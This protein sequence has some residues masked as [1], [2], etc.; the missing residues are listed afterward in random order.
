[1]MRSGK[2]FR[3]IHTINGSVTQTLLM[4][5]SIL[6]LAVFT[7]MGSFTAS[8]Q[9]VPQTI[10]EVITPFETS[11]WVY[12]DKSSRLADDALF[13]SYASQLGLTSR[14][15]MQLEA[16]ETD[17]FGWTHREYQQVHNGVPVEFAVYN[18]HSRDGI[19]EKANG[20]IAPRLNVQTAP[21]IGEQEALAIALECIGAETYN[22]QVPQLEVMKRYATDDPNATFYPEGQLLIADRD[23][24]PKN[25]SQHTLAWK[26]EIHSAKPS[27]RDWVYVDA[28]NGI[29]LKELD[30]CMHE[31]GYP[32]TAETR[33]NGTVEIITD[34]T[35]LGF[36][37]RDYT[38]GRGI[39]TYDAADSF[40]VNY[41]VDFVDD[42]NYWAN[43]NDRA[44]DAATDCHWAA[45][46]LYDYL[47]EVHGFDSYD[48]KGSKMLSYVH[49]GQSWFNA[50]WNGFWSQ[51]G[52]AS[53]EPWV[54]VD[55][56]GHE[57]AHGFTWASAALLYT[58]ESGAMNESF[59]DILG[60][61]LQYHING[62]VTDWLATPSPVDTIRD[63]A[64]PNNHGHPDTYLGDNWVT[65]P[66]DNFGVHSNSG[67]Q[68]KWF[69]LLVNGGQGVNDNGEEYAVNPI[70]IDAAMQVVMRSMTTYLFPEA[71]YSDGRQSSLY[72][73]E[74]IFGVC[75]EEYRQIANAWHAVGV[76]QRV[77]EDDF[78]IM[79]IEE[80]P[81]CNVAEDG[82]LT[83]NLRHMGC[84]S[85][86]AVNISARVSKSNPPLSYTEVIDIPEG[87]G[88]GEV[89]SYTFNETFD[90]ARSGEHTLQIFLSSDADE[91]GGN[92]VSPQVSVFQLR[93]VEEHDFRFYTN[94]APRTFRDSM[95]FRSSQFSTLRI[96]NF[97]GR[98]ST[99]GILIEGDRMR[100]G[101]VVLEGED[102]FDYNQRQGTEICMCMDATNLDSLGL[103]FDLR[104]T[105][106]SKFEERVQ[107]PQPKT[108]AM[109]IMAN[110]EE[111]VRYFPETNNDDE[112]QTHNLD[113]EDYLGLEFTL[114]F[115]TR[116]IQSLAEDIDSIGDRVF[117]D[118]II[119]Q[120]VEIASGL[121]NVDP[122]LP[123]SI[124]PNPAS[125][126]YNV[127]FESLETGD[128]V[129]RVF[130]L[131]GAL[132]VQRDVSIAQ[133]VNRITADVYG[134]GKGIYVVEIASAGQRFVGRLAVL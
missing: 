131:N 8:S 71:T 82:Q 24:D 90:F 36:V 128:G 48:N 89:F 21:S 16:I 94:I 78:A 99:T 133:G 61:A 83:I 17:E 92:D 134:L 109:R 116:T 49:Y 77:D 126:E 20:V 113:L 114:C 18:V 5:R 33:Y 74:D 127:D 68:N 7:A 10:D 4:K 98:D 70:G 88:P 103:Q 12:I 57:F 73:A 23:F 107:I 28:N 9:N 55:V 81:L 32:G 124:F 65:T 84:D 100:Y 31:N 130:D 95:S 87:V 19:A 30:L 35:E 11:N 110:G 108:S 132:M 79:S 76:G 22:W 43:S 111:L 34:S 52:D 96:L 26:F 39:E 40:S 56:V 50:S 125:G 41:A 105:Y 29:I 63:Y 120:S 91:N 27:S 25:K 44:D 104:Q 121:V 6:C 47:K 62:G 129:M 53:G 102:P 66:G 119:I 13:T 59:S 80:Y 58:R 45:E 85:S 97:V 117:L 93:P 37:L 15:E 54:N 106:S 42:D 115:E 14:D 46:Q 67:V 64:Q 123:V 101:K 3:D 122:T 51:Y 2:F 69:Y 38:R 118:N 60:E 86:S 75:S 112:W 72:S 1:M